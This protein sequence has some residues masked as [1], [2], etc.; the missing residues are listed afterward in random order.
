MDAVISGYIFQNHIYI[1]CCMIEC[2]EQ[3]YVHDKKKNQNMFCFWVDKMPYHLL[4]LHYLPYVSID[5][6]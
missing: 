5:K 6:L 2:H 1:V 3:I 4:L